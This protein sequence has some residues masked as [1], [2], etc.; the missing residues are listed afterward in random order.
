[1]KDGIGRTVLLLLALAGIGAVAYQFA[2]GVYVLLE[3]IPYDVL[4]SV[5]AAIL[6]SVWLAY[7]KWMIHNRKSA[8][9]ARARR[10]RWMVADSGQA[11]VPKPLVSTPPYDMST[12]EL[13][14]HQ[15]RLTGKPGSLGAAAVGLELIDEYLD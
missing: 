9:V 13:E 14:T 5:G 8:R 7:I 10:A 1:M 12:L 3:L 11:I 6:I 2:S 15:W 4:W